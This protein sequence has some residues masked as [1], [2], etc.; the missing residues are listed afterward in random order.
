MSLMTDRRFQGR[1][2]TSVKCFWA[3]FHF[4]LRRVT[5]RFDFFSPS[6]VFVVLLLCLFRANLWPDDWPCWFSK[7]IERT[8]GI[9]VVT[10]WQIKGRSGVVK[11]R[12]PTKC[13]WY[14]WGIRIFQ[15]TCYISPQISSCHQNLN[16]QLKLLHVNVAD[17]RS[18]TKQIII[19]ITHWKLKSQHR[20]LP[21]KKN[22][23]NN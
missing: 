6:L 22:Q 21:S 23:L 10:W 9:D 18:S 4:V 12:K 16:I 17:I 19:Q 20:F 3:H 1:H 15:T 14:L 2:I 8:E 11:T 13:W 7:Q 5:I